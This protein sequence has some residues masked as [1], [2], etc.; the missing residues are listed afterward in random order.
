[1]DADRTPKLYAY[2]RLLLMA[3]PLLLLGALLFFYITHGGVVSTDDA[4]VQAARTE[5]S[6]NIGGRITHVAARE[7]TFVH[8]GDV[9]F[10]LDDRDYVIAVQ[11]AKAQL[12]N[13]KL[14][15]MAMKATYKQREAAV[16]TANAA[17]LYH[18]RELQRQEPLLLHGIISKTQY[19]QSHL[20][21]LT[22]R[23]QLFA[24]EHEVENMRATLGE[25][26]S[27]DTP[28]HPMVQHAQ[29]AL[30]R[31]LLDLSYTVV[32]APADGIVT[33]VDQLQV[34]DY[35]QPATPVFA[36]VSPH[37][38]WIEANFKETE[39]AHI[40]PGQAAEIA[41]DL[42]P[43]RVFHGKV[44]SLSPGTGAS[45]SLLPPENATGN[46]V[47]VV[48]RLP[49]RISLEDLDGETRLPMGLSATVTVD[50]HPPEKA[51]AS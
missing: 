6:A 35:I 16:V 25:D 39:L 9:L 43:D 48:Q 13:A 44:V 45:F 41:L 18:T 30:D 34:G 32:C 10:T 12:A 28:M 50:I 17:V 19:D 46:W 20:A 49:V 1:M 36:L 4:Y 27:L 21:L 38:V 8:E 33:K 7:N 37:T 5:I 14:Q 40:V 51:K 47:K 31:A 3:G 23:Q 2:R 29:A 22:A 26:P 24:A 15:I 11:E 42:Y